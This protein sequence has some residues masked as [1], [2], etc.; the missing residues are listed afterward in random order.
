MDTF[1][2]IIVVLMVAFVVFWVFIGRKVFGKFPG[3][4][5]DQKAVLKYFA[6][7]NGSGCFNTVFKALFSIS[8]SQFDAILTRRVQQYDVFAMALQALNLDETQVQ[9]VAPIFFDGYV[10][11]GDTEGIGDDHVYRSSKYQLSCV[12]S[13]PEQAY[14]YQYTFNLVDNFYSETTREIFYKEVTAV[15]TQTKILDLKVVSGCGFRTEYFPWPLYSFDITVPSS[16]FSC[17]TRDDMR[18]QIVGLKAH[19]LEKKR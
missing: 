11:A 6:G 19:L 17:A 15:E 18:Q 4:T 16:T 9:E 13:S 2:Q 7:I 1:I 5:V 14:L 10:P 3:K 12:L 8:D